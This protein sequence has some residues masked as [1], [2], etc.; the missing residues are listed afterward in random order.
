MLTQTKVF[1]NI[2]QRSLRYILHA[3]MTTQPYLVFLRLM[4]QMLNWLDQEGLDFIK[5]WWI[6]RLMAGCRWVWLEEVGPW[7][8]VWKP[9]SLLPGCREENSFLCSASS[10]MMFCP[11]KQSHMLNPWVKMY[12]VY[13]KGFEYLSQ[14]QKFWLTPCPTHYQVPGKCQATRSTSPHMRESATAHEQKLKAY[15]RGLK[16]KDVVFALWADRGGTEMK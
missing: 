10:V 16:E 11:K 2:L 1:I 7:G 3:T 5:R 6:H 8:R 13:F 4:S 14:F 9:C 12:L 15:P